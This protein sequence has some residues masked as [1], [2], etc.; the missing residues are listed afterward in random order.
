MALCADLLRAQ[1]QASAV[2]CVQHCPGHPLSLPALSLTAP[3]KEVVSF[4]SGYRRI[5]GGTVRSV[6]HAD[7]GRRRE[8]RFRLGPSVAGSRT[9]SPTVTIQ[10]PSQC[11]GQ[12]EADADPDADGPNISARTAGRRTFTKIT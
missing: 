8:P 3:L 6:L 9:R 12:G 4:F 7:I 5:N 11:C 1:L 2:H 10:W